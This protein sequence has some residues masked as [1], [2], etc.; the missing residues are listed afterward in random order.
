MDIE[1]T[2]LSNAEFYSKSSR[3]LTEAE[4]RVSNRKL[5]QQIEEL[6][7]WARIGAHTG[8]TDSNWTAAEDILR[9][10]DSGEFS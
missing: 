3:A 2:D 6:L 5:K 1:R 9:R 10:I 8:R 7:V 4:L